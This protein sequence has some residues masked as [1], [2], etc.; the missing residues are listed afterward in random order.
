MGNAESYDSDSHRGRSRHHSRKQIDPTQLICSKL[1]EGL[2]R[3]DSDTDDSD[4]DGS[5][6]ERKKTRRRKEEKEKEYKSR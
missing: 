1:H 5:T 6:Y 4:Y 2:N 3:F